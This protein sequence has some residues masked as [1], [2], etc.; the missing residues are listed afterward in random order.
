MVNAA[1]YIYKKVKD[2]HLLT[3]AFNWDKERGTQNFQ[4]VCV[5]HSLGGGT[6]AILAIM[7]KQ[8]YPD[9]KCFSF[10]PPGGLL[11]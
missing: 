1:G 8:E 9:T 10:S 6:A 3:K 5:G 7:L 11:R 2:E 4:L